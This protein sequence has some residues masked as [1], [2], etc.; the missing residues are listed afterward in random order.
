MSNGTE[1]SHVSVA[2]PLTPWDGL[3]FN[4][5]P[6][7]HRM[8]DAQADGALQAF[9]RV[10]AEAFW[11][12]GLDIAR[13]ERNAFIETCDDWT[14]PYLA[15]LLGVE[16]PSGI[17]G[18]PT[19]GPRVTAMARALAPRGAVA[20]T[21]ARRRRKG[22]PGALQGLAQD[23]LGQPARVVEF[24]RTTLVL[25]RTGQP[26]AARSR[27][28]SVRD[29][30]AL[31]RLGGVF[32]RTP[33]LFDS[34]PAGPF[35]TGRGRSNASAGVFIWQTSLN[36]VDRGQPRAV[37]AFRPGRTPCDDRSEDREPF[38]L[39]STFHPLGIEVPLVTRP[40]PL[41]DPTGAAAELEVPAPIRREA[42]DD[43]AR[44][45]LLYGP[46]RSLVVW[47]EGPT[48]PGGEPTIEPVPA[49][50]IVVV[51][52]KRERPTLE[53]GQV[54]VDPVHGLLARWI[55]P[56]AEKPL[57]V[58]FHDARLAPIGGGD[59]DRPSR[60]IP[61]AAAHVYVRKVDDA[62]PDQEALPAGT[63]FARS[64]AGAVAE[65][66]A[67]PE[68]ERP[69]HAV[70]EV[71]DDSTYRERWEFDLPG[72][73]TL[74]LRAGRGRR[75]TVAL[76]RGKRARVISAGGATLVLDGLTIARDAIR[77][78]G[79]FARVV[80]RD[81][82]LVPGRSLRRDGRS[83]TPSAPSLWLDRFEGSVTILRS[84]LG[85]VVVAR[86]NRH[87]EPPPL[88]LSQSLLDAGAGPGACEA[89][90]GPGCAAAYAALRVDRSTIV[91][92]VEVHQI[93]EALDSLFDGEVVAAR[94]P[95]GV[96][97]FCYSRPAPGGRFATPRRF[98]C[99]PDLALAQ[100]RPA[101][102]PRYVSTRFSHA[103][104]RQLAPD[105]DAALLRGASDGGELGVHHDLFLSAKLENLERQLVEF[106]PVGL[107][108][109]IV[110]AD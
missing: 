107:D 52:L 3:I 59:Y 74:E 38:L 94:R 102:A 48:P 22:T 51:D 108:V 76:R 39:I 21:V 91:G 4:R 45:P 77:L 57:R 34:R 20:N 46:G 109:T 92:R 83:A 40:L 95:I 50:K 9:S 70:V 44:R 101:P 105:G 25:P 10:L 82:T 19:S 62:D 31:D 75:P 32:D 90:G 106:T 42:L 23:L 12:I 24:R 73:M 103:R 14:V 66:L 29:R 27:L 86:P 13:L 28:P 93:D 54:A 58:S 99:Q 55:R 8:R 15:E 78:V 81:V 84:I 68:A 96:M 36:R 26:A 72:G 47:S 63:P 11:I 37:E 7:F 67:R 56:G 85:R 89:L 2:D 49:R 60:P 43:P 33:R 87:A 110:T 17:I 79:P 88:C 69:V 35:G 53:S 64:I 97:E 104:Y 6:V 16:P 71:M 30:D 65:L 98:Q 5:L 100:G 80:I 18:A 61:S 41:S 1:L